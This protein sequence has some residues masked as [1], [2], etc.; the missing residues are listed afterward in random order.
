MSTSVFRKAIDDGVGGV[1]AG[2][3][4]LFWSMVMTVSLIPGMMGFGMWMSTRPGV[5]PEQAALIMDKI[6]TICSL[7]AAAFATIVAAVGAFRMG[8]KPRHPTPPTIVGEA[9]RVTVNP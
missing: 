5:S 7:L 4:A 8:D 9:N 2:Y 6:G 3:L 1:D